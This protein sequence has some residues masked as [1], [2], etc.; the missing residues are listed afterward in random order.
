MVVAVLVPVN[1]APRFA[2]EWMGVVLGPMVALVLVLVSRWAGLSWDE[3]GLAGRSWRRGAGYAAGAVGLAGAVYALGVALPWTRVA[4]LDV[5]YHLSAGRALLT[6]LA[7]IPLRTVLLE[8]VAFR[9]VLL[10]LLRRHRGGL[11]ASAVSSALFGLWHI[12]PSLAL[13]G[14]NRA[15]GAVVG[16]GSGAQLS[17]VTAAVL[18]TT[19]AGVVFCEL[20]R[21]SGSLLASA[22][23][24]W[25]INGFGV[26][27]AA[28]LWTLHRA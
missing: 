11:W 18:F 10:G 2:P 6:A 15:L 23:L 20:R 26:L 19:V 25:A 1:L 27:V 16:Q 9:G 13:S 22:G 21:R 7:L 8:E 17:A 28:G 12:V 14:T 24:H 5:R 3:L 4:F